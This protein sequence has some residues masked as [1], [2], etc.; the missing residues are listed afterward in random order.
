MGFAARLGF[1]P[2]SD[3]ESRQKTWPRTELGATDKFLK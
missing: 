1:V 3:V 2:T